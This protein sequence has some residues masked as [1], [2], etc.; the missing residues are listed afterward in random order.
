M[1]KYK[2]KKKTFEDDYVNNIDFDVILYFMI[3]VS[4]NDVV[5]CLELR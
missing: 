5:K 2:K 4:I 1:K 3:K